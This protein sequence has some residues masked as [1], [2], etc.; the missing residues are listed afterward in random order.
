MEYKELL[1]K[2]RDIPG[3]LSTNKQNKVESNII[4]KSWIEKM[5][6]EYSKK[7]NKNSK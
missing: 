1:N 7:I 4:Y 3:C 2:C 5:D 6:I